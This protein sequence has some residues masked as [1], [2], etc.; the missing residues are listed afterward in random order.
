M[1]NLALLTL[2]CAAP[3]DAQ[4]ASA[5]AASQSYDELYLAFAAVKP[6]G[7]APKDKQAIAE[8]LLKGALA[9]EPSDA[10]LAASLA[11]KSVAFNPSALGYRCA[12]R[13]AMV[14]D[15]KGAAEELLKA[16]GKK[17]P[18]DSALAY[19]LGRFLLED[20][21]VEGALAALSRI[22]KGAPELAD[23]QAL[24]ERAKAQRVERDAARREARRIETRAGRETARPL[25][26]ER[27]VPEAQGGGGG[28]GVQSGVGPGGVRVRSSGHF[29]FKYF[30]GDRDFAQR[31]D[32]EGRVAAALDSAYLFAR[33]ELGK[34]R[35][36]P[37]DV[38]LYTREEF[39][40]HHG[41]NAAQTFAG[42]YSQGA[43]RISDAAEIS[44]RT[45][46]TLV[47]EYI[48]AVVDEF[49]GGRPERLPTWMNEGLAEL[50]EWRYQGGDRPPL[51]LSSRMKGAA[52]RN[53]L[54]SLKQMENGMLGGGA[55]GSVRYGVSAL[56][57]KALLREGGADN[58]LTLFREV[59]KGRD[60]AAV[61]A[62]RYSIKL[63]ALDRE[64]QSE[65]SRR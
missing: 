32:Y 2:L 28:G 9:L 62:E 14:T 19:E 50:I 48:H 49:S 7:Y 36:A 35:E 13:M 15:Q 39:A 61:Y 53:S 42:L 3:P 63:D 54:P 21:D 18:Q 6:D 38:V 31:S 46:A 58:L 37:V 22:K 8:A 65:L 33:K 16:G 1:L 25:A 52:A 27:L 64:I 23:A 24:I 59:G 29:V 60:F 34:S 17:F 45:Q 47:H 56:A 41:A 55:D 30:G 5:L 20:E 43:M 44:E 51:W 26:Q 4:R 40:L 11:E 12:A 57:V 10:V